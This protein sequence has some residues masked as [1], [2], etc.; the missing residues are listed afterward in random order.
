VCDR[1]G[2]RL[3][4]RD[5]DKPETVEKRLRVYEEETRP[6]I[7]F[8]RE[9]GLLREVSGDLEVREGRKAI[10]DALVMSTPGRR[11]APSP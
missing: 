1:C 8:Y 4:Q 7:R 9:R 3:I 5:D 11:R 10:K 2:G 6:L